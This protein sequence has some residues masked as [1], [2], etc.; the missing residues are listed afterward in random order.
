MR[1]RRRRREAEARR[2]EAGRLQDELAH[3]RL[4]VGAVESKADS[5]AERIRAIAR[6]GTAGA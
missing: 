6:E 4:L 3:L 2:E 1:P 5:A